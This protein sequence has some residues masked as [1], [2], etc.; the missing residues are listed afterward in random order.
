MPGKRSYSGKK[1]KTKGKMVK[2]DFKT[3]KIVPRW[4]LGGFPDVYTAKLRYVQEFTVNAGA[5]AAANQVFRANGIYDPDFAIGGHQPMNSDEFYAVY[6]SSFVS[7]SKITVRWAPSGTSNLTPGVVVIFKND[8]EDTLLTYDIEQILEQTN[9]T[10]YK[11]FGLA[12]APTVQDYSPMVL[13]YSPTK[14]LGVKDPEDEDDLR[15]TIAAGPTK[16]YYFEIYSVAIDGNDPGPI[17]FIATIDYLVTFQNRIN[18]LG[19]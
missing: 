17:H 4:P 2:V 13:T 11:L 14:D 6:G 1:K 5:A 8:V 16:E 9:L 12:D 7:G 3:H 18:N 15:G 19:S 10:G